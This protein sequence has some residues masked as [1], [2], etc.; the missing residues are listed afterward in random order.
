MHALCSTVVPRLQRMADSL[1][2]DESS[3]GNISHPIEVLNGLT[4]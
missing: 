2:D 3:N 1:T 4:D